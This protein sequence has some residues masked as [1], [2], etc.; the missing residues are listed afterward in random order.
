MPSSLYIR[1]F[2]F[3]ISKKKC[4]ALRNGIVSAFAKRIAAQNAPKR[5]PAAFPRAVFRN[6]FHRIL[7]ARRCKAATRRQ[8][9][10]DI[11]FITADDCDQYPLHFK[12]PALNSPAR[13]SCVSIASRILRNGASMIVSR[14]MKIRFVPPLI[15]GIKGVTASRMRR[16]TRFRI[17]AFPIFLLTEKPIFA[18]E[19]RFF[20]YTS[21]RSF[22]PQDL[23]TR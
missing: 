6:R 17:T 20:A 5:K 11:F 7:R 9:W 12:S 2:D 10:R 21:E 4:L 13:C 8:Q 23:P 16:F 18:L 15:D 22:P 19:P 14:A 1:V 3:K